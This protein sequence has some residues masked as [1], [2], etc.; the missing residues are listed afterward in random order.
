MGFV[1]FKFKMA[2]GTVK[3]KEIMEEMGLAGRNNDQVRLAR[4]PLKKTKGI[5]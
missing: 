1:F 2:N 3:L 5:K 4:I